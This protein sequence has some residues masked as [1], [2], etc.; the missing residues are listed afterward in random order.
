[1]QADTFERLVLGQLHETVGPADG[2]GPDRALPAGARRQDRIAHRGR[3][4]VGRRLLGRRPGVREPI[5]RF[6]EKIG[7]AFQ[8][9][10]DVIDLSPQPE[11]TGKAPG[12]DLRAGVATL[13]LLRLRRAREDG[14]GIR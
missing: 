8:L 9:I 6:G 5:D 10:D 1:M 11:E 4:A 7:V 12:T 3:R 13:P 2:R 14:C